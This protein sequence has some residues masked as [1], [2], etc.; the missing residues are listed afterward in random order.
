M[1]YPV[2]AGEKLILLT[3]LD[4]TS[5]MD[6]DLIK[7]KLRYPPAFMPLD[8]LEVIVLIAKAMRSSAESPFFSENA[9]NH[10]KLSD[11]D[12]K[13]LNQP[14]EAVMK[15]L[16]KYANFN[17]PDVKKLKLVMLEWDSFMNLSVNPD[18]PTRTNVICEVG[19]D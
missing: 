11:K 12:R 3:L 6:T 19:L 5:G 10:F 2:V 8:R 9:E 18:H 14:V 13:L 17:K 16:L 4:S 15:D 1:S 7:G